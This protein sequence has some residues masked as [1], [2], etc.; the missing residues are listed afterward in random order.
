MR[1]VPLLPF[2]VLLAACTSVSMPQER[3][4]GAQLYT[5]RADMERDAFATL[6][7]VA[8][9]GFDEIEFAGTFG[10]EPADL[11]REAKRN[12]LEVAATHIDWQLLRDDPQ[13]A[14]DHAVGLCADTL[15]LAWLPPEERRSEPQWRWWIAQLNHVNALAQARNIRVA[16]HAHDFE[17]VPVDAVFMPIDL[18]MDGLHPAVGIELDSFWFE[19]SG[20]NPVD[21][22]QRYPGRVTHLHLK[23]MASDG[24]MADVGSGQIDFPAIIAE[25]ERQ[26]VRHLLVERDD[27]PD[28]WASLATSL[29]S[30]RAIPLQRETSPS[31]LRSAPK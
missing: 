4:I 21:F 1:F 16:Y 20:V 9:L 22:M 26:G 25:A 13:A 12:G 27:A 31:P 14:V 2:V 23:D 5:V 29:D 7:R 11:C 28:P 24:A 15:V 10:H 8:A 17:F 19:S 3:R 18:L 6:Q 30:L